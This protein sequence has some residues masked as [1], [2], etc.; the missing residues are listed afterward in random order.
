MD[1][2]EIKTL[3]KFLKYFWKCEEIAQQ[4]GF[5]L[6]WTDEL[7]SFQQNFLNLID[8]KV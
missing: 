1:K 6:K 5:N 7:S 8:T 2:K 3:R 4:E